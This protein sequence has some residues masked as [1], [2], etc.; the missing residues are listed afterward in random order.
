VRVSYRYIRPCPVLYAR[1]VGAYAESAVEAWR[2]MGLWLD[3]HN[4]RHLIKRGLGIFHDDPTV[5]GAEALRYD[6]CVGFVPGLALDAEP[7][8][9]IGR[10]TLAGGAYAVHVHAGTY[11]A[12]GKL[13]STLRRDAVNKRGL[14]VD[15]GRPFIAIYL[16]DPM[17]TRE[18]HRR[19][20]LC[21]PVMPMRMPASSNDEC[22]P[23]PSNDDIGVQQRCTA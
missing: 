18:M 4:A 9:R 21:V 7:S 11:E 3:A 14:S 5:T 23:E 6:A 15:Y 2:T 20:E 1:T 13:F 17:F 10:Q 16:N 22:A 8:A 12:T 19:T